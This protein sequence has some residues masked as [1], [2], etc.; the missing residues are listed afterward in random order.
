MVAIEIYFF[1]QVMYMYYLLG[2]RL[3]EEP[4]EEIEEMLKEKL[5]R[6]DRLLK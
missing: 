1:L 2:Y 3:F 4:H 5:K 6:W